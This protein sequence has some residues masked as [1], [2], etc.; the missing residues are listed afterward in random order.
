M[1]H[2]SKASQLPGD[3]N[4]D[5]RGAGTK[6]HRQVEGSDVLLRLQKPDG[7]RKDPPSSFEEEFTLERDD[8]LPLRFRGRLIG[9]NEVDPDTPRGTEVRIYAT[10]R[11]KIVTAVHQWQKDVKRDRERHSAA[12]HAVP[13]EA[14]AWLKRDGGGHLGKASKSAWDLACKT[15]P[16]LNGRD[17]EIVE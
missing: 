16:P 10:R 12:A 17:V 9:W 14:L 7:I 3:S 2:D 1:K 11:G 4:T 15:W 6:V 8:D 5:E 13:E